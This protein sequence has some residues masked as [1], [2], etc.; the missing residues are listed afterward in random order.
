VRRLLTRPWLVA[1]LAV[2]LYAAGL[3]PYYT[4]TAGGADSSG[5][6]AAARL[7]AAG[8]VSE[9]V[10][11]IPEL[12]SYR[13]DAR[14]VAPLGMNAAPGRRLLVP[15]YPPGFPL[16]LAAALRVL[17]ERAAMATTLAVLLAASLLLLAGLGRAVGLSWPWTA[18]AT[19]LLAI[20]PVFLFMGVQPMSD[21]AALAWAEA[22]MLGAWL[23]HRHPRW[24]W[25]AGIAVGMAIA[26]RPSNIVLFAPVLV[27]LPWSREA[28]WRF[29][30]GGVPWALGLGWYN[31]VAHGAPWQTGYPGHFDLFSPAW[32]APTLGHYATWV[33][34]FLSWPVVALAVAMPWACRRQPRVAL[35]LGTW[36][37]AYVGFYAMYRFTHETWWYLRFVLPAYPAVIL[38]ALLSAQ[39]VT[40][41][42]ARGRRAVVLAGVVLVVCSAAASI[43]R[44]PEAREWRFVAAGEERYRVAAAWLD[45]SLR[46]NAVI[47]T[48]QMSGALHLYTDRP[49]LRWE[50]VFDE[51]WPLVERFVA[52]RARRFYAILFPF[53]AEEVFGRTW[54]PLPGRWTEVDR[55]GDI[56]LWRYE[57]PAPVQSR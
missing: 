20:Q 34:R 56:G 46:R 18:A 27:V 13:L 11:L 47:T 41:R 8:R 28:W 40:T 7:F 44:R 38:A 17:P 29:L 1:T 37:L 24:A 39:H 54:R 33:P 9:R 50:Y 10:R 14:A 32:I 23:A 25:L 49:F 35:A 52:A 21:V 43:A 45:G 36:A 51:D 2:G 5:Y 42:V 22:A 48:M 57:G 19:I 30:A 6:L 16:H 55:F 15:M 4:T 53:E 26:V 31:A 12:E 3:A